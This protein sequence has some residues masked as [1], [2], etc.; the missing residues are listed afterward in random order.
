MSLKFFMFVPILTFPYNMFRENKKNNG[1]SRQPF[2]TTFVD[3]NIYP[4]HFPESIYLNFPTTLS[5][6]HSISENSR[7]EWG[8]VGNAKA[9]S[10]RLPVG[11]RGSIEYP[12]IIHG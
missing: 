4:Q 5:Q 8:G 6:Q 1:M 12:L 2:P 11:S 10:P 9:E 7:V 3:L